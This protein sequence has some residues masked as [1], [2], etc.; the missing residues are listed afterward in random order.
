MNTVQKIFIVMKDSPAIRLGSPE[1]AYTTK[2]AA[3]KHVKNNHGPFRIVPQYLDENITK[4]PR[5]IIVLYYDP[6]S[7]IRTHI[8]DIFMDQT[9]E[10]QIY[11][12]KIDYLPKV[13]PLQEEYNSGLASLFF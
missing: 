8:V 2:K 13:I 6:P 7:S 10:L 4:V 1:I 5:D 9:K 3:K 11:S 12:R